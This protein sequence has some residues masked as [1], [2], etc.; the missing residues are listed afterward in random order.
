MKLDC[1]TLLVTCSAG[2]VAVGMANM[3]KELDTLP[4]ASGEE[5]AV[6]IHEPLVPNAP[7][8]PDEPSKRSKYGKR[9]GLLGVSFA[10]NV[11]TFAL[12]G[13]FVWSR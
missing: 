11:I 7:R 8:T 12:V 5:S 9:C 3:D 1:S 6:D 4:M 10:E 2:L 13:D